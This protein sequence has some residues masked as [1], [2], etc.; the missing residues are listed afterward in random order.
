MTDQ[1]HEA[2]DSSKIPTV[3]DLRPDPHVMDYLLLLSKHKWLVLSLIFVTGGLF[4]AGTYFVPQ[5]YQATALILPPDRASTAGMLSNLVEGSALSILKQVEN[6]SVDLLQ[7]LLESRSMAER[8]AI[9]PVIRSYF[10]KRFETHDEFINAIHDAIHIRPSISKLTVDGT[11]WTGWNATAAE[12]EAARQ[13]SARMTNLALATM[14]SMFKSEFRLSSH[15]ARIHAE[16][17][18]LARSAELDSLDRVQEEFE[19]AHGVVSIKAQ[20]MEAV[21]Q[22][23]KLEAN[24]EE[25]RI[26]LALAEREYSTQ[27]SRYRQALAEYEEA[28]RTAREFSTREDVGP[29]LSALPEV[30]RRYAEILRRKA[31]LEPIITY[32]RVVTEQERLNEEKEKSLITVLDPARPP[33]LR[34]SP[35]RFPMLQLGLIV[36]AALSILFLG[37][38]SL[39][40]SWK[41]ELRSRR[42]SRAGLIT[43]SP[44]GSLRQSSD[45]GSRS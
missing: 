14:D 32:L 12:K 11:I 10:I 17:D 43:S 7:N 6:P 22:L 24:R 8:L 34:F 26:K 37:L 20:T 1:A 39:G 28:D 35:K 30:G 15:V 16:A 5:S 40:E 18:Y 31:S 13:L 2:L 3:P 9:D 4:L 27:S 23:G 33:E 36:G 38:R 44:S 45:A 21:T 42:A 25:D 29:S 41:A 19:K